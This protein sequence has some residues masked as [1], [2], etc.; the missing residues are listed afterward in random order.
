MLNVQLS[1]L[2]V[3][4]MR[5]A[6]KVKPRALDALEYPHA[7]APAP[8]AIHEIAPGVY[9]LRMPLPFALEHINLWLLADGDGWTIVD[10]GFGGDPTRELWR[11]IFA[12]R[13]HGKPVARIIVTHFHPDHFGLAAWLAAQWEAPVLMS[14]P[15]FA[16][17]QAWHTSR[18]P[19]TREGHLALFQSHGLRLGADNEPLQRNNLF[20]RGVPDLPAQIVPLTDHQTLQINGRAWRVVFGYGHSPEHAALCC[21]DLGVLIAGDIVLPRISTNVSVQPHLPDADPLGL[22][23]DSLTRYAECDA[24]TLVLPS[25]GLPFYGLRERVKLLQQHHAERLDELQRACVEPRTGAEVMPVL[26]KRELDPQ[27]TLFA[28]GET[29]SHLNYLRG[30]GQLRRERGADGLYRF[31]CN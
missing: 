10:C 3:N 18:A 24:R 12:C 17:A 5:S 29:L 30:R 9:W 26:F 28:M 21:D 2:Y 7:A 16:S 25:H 14:E 13:L 15:E 31:T 20:R 27:Q 1:N 11:R 23:L 8:A 22:F 4:V 19:F 6:A